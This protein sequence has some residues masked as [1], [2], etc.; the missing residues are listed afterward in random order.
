MRRLRSPPSLGHRVK[1]Q[2]AA[3]PDDLD[4]PDHEAPKLNSVV[5]LDEAKGAWA[6][7]RLAV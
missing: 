6:S 5:A 4:C 2:K 1:A 3:P 7:L